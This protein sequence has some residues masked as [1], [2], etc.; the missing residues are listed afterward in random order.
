MPIYEYT[1]QDCGGS[2]ETIR[3]MKDADAELACT[4][5][6]SHHIKRNL[7]LFNAASGGIALTTSNSSCGGCAGGSCSSCGAN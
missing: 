2:F 4:H 3:A 5:C 7:S 6:Q 1:C